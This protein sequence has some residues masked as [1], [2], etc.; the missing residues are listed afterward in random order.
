MCVINV[1]IIIIIVIIIV[2]IIISSHIKRGQGRASLTTHIFIL[3]DI[4]VYMSMYTYIHKS[5]VCM[6]LLYIYIYIYIVYFI[7]RD[8]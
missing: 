8:L 7:E 4:I 3:C 2:I 5:D 6:I 1:I